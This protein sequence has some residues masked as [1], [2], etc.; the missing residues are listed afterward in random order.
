MLDEF[1]DFTTN[2]VN[3]TLKPQRSNNF[4]L[5]MRYFFNDQSYVHLNFYRLDTTDEIYLNP[6][7]FEFGIV[8]N[9]NL[10]GK[11]RRDGAEIAFKLAAA[12]WLSVNGSYTYTDAKIRDGQF[13][14]KDIPDVPNHKAALGTTFFW[15]QA[16][17]TINGVYIGERP[18]VSD[19]ENQFSKQED[20]LIFNL[21]LKYGWKTFTAFL[22][23]NN[24]TDEEYSE[25]GVIS[26]Y[27]A[28]REKAF[29]PSPERN[30]LVGLR[31]DF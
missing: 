11:T 2:T 6:T 16:S 20:H 22:D 28:P 18:F 14:G 19:F 24:I 3:S 8:G 31:I 17:F 21:K 29:Y 5:G 12:K 23:V 1:F 9:D 13:K 7:P 4:E 15:N 30:F 10:D 27:S 26:L 25:Y